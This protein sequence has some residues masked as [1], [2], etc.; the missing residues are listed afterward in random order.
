MVKKLINMTYKSE[1]GFTLIEVMI[2][3]AIFAVFIVAFTTSQGF[4]LADSTRMKEELM[5]R[6]LAE[7]KMNEVIITPPEFKDSITLTPDKGKFEGNEEYSY[8]V[9]YSR[10]K[11]DIEKLMGVSA[12]EGEDESQTSAAEKQIMTNITKNLKELVW[13]VEVKITSNNSGNSF[14]ISSWLYNNKAKIL[15][16]SI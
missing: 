6:T 11:L 1:K 8:E 10:L 3:L 13:Q 5:F 9:T 12:S 2:A 14:Y 16:D 15:F 4:N 7:Q